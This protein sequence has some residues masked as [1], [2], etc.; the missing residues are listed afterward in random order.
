MFDSTA[1]AQIYPR[2]WKTVELDDSCPESFMTYIATIT[3]PTFTTAAAVNVAK[4][5]EMMGD[6]EYC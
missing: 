2:S 6:Y 1:G 5:Y 4:N 3:I